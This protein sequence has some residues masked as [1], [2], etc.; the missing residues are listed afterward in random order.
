MCEACGNSAPPTDTVARLGQWIR[1]STKIVAASGVPFHQDSSYYAEELDPDDAAAKYP[2]FDPVVRRPASLIG[3]TERVIV[4][5]WLPLVDVDESNGCLRFV[6]GSHKLGLLP[7]RPK[8]DV[9]TGMKSSALE[10]VQRP[11][12]YGS[13]VPVPM[14]VGSVLFFHNNVL[15]GSEGFTRDRHVRWSID[16]RYGPADQVTPLPIT[17]SLSALLRL[18]NVPL[19]QPFD[20][21]GNTRWIE[22][23]P[24]FLS[25]SSTSPITPWEEW[26]K[27]WK[28]PRH[29]SAPKL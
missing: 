4:S 25:R 13:I 28:T 16:L 29:M 2:P 21:H 12:S 22:E 26:E 8:L 19:L 9:K 10:P 3:G 27:R 23:W 18:T 1:P 15:H 17:E 11:E 5:L 7:V 24:P 14:R 6:E 20:W